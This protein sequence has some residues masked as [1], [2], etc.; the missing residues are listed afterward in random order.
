VVDGTY[1]AT[2]RVDDGLER[3]EAMQRVDGTIVIAADSEAGVD[4]V[5]FA[6]GLDDDHSEFVRRFANDPLLGETLRPRARV[7]ARCARRPWRRRC[8]APVAGQLILASEATQDRAA[9][10]QGDRH[11]HSAI[12]TPLRPPKTLRATPPRSSRA[13]GSAPAVRRR[14][15]GYAARSTSKA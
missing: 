3:V 12:Y 15:S 7:A 5:R 2:I 9:H 8:C 11:R 4:H 10:H 14:S 1:R 6:L 13:S